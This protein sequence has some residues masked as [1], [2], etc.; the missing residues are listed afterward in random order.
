MKKVIY[1]LI[2]LLYVAPAFVWSQP[3]EEAEAKQSFYQFKVIYTKPG[4]TT[5]ELRDALSLVIKSCELSPSNYKYAFVAAATYDVLEEYGKAIEWY[6]K[7]VE[8]ATNEKQRLNAEVAAR[9]SR[10]MLVALRNRAE[11]R[12]GHEISVTMML[13]GLNY[14]PE[15]REGQD[16]P[17][18]FPVNL[19]P[20]ERPDYLE[21]LFRDSQ[22]LRNP[23]FL[24]ISYKSRNTAKEHYERGVKD[25]YNYFQKHLFDNTKHKPIILFLGDNPGKLIDLTNELY[26]NLR[27]RSEHPF[28]GYF[29]KKDN[30]IF[31]TVWGGY[32]TLLHEMIHALIL[33]DYPEPPGWLGE[34]FATI[35]ERTQWT[36]NRL[37]P[38]PNWR[39]GRMDLE[40]AASLDIY[41]K[42]KGDIKLDYFDLAKLRLLYIYLDE[43]GQLKAFY[44]A[45]K[46]SNGSKSAA[47]IARDLGVEQEAW[48]DFVENSIIDYQIDVAKHRGRS[49]NPAETRY[50]Q[51]ALNVVMDAGLKEDGFW[52]SATEAMLK[53]FQ[54]S[55]GL[56]A[57]GI[58]GKNTRA[59]LQRLFVEKTM[60]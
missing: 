53:S 25:F 12:Q 27:F 57:D 5:A 36:N 21:H 48:S 56:K 20:Q 19:L 13:K 50:I 42:Y 8:I 51:R 14:E 7:A 45:V 28:M 44:Q 49:V 32:G 60:E 9:E 55:Q 16:L 22:P 41:E 40:D 38:L 4:V 52:G 15:L 47:Q 2:L 11:S 54:A 30:V 23:N 39:M 43:L 58:Y 33:A 17:T 34:A 10:F 35:Y 46:A 6:R 29:N 3:A 24:I 1:I 18:M 31:A 26:P 59:A 37:V